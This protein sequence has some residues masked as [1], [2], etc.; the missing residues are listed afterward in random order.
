M[1]SPEC[2]FTWSWTL[3]AVTTLS[4]ICCNDD[5]TR[6]IFKDR[7]SVFSCETI[8][9]TGYELALQADH[10]AACG[11]SSIFPV[12]VVVVVAFSSPTRIW[13]KIF[14]ALI[15]ACALFIYLFIFK[16]RLARAHKFHYL[17]QYIAQ[18]AKKTVAKRNIKSCVFPDSI[19]SPLQLR[20]VKAVWVLRRNL[21]PALSEEWLGSFT[22][23]CGNTGLER[24]PNKSRHR[25][26]TPEK[27]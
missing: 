10:S 8:W 7:H 19:V 27:K 23:H 2:E 26:L 25:K 6:A 16:W 3:C 5:R 13:G 15:P 17:S 4:H 20:L 14:V 9:S 22:C 21:S 18:R 24:T 12:V 1:I 11:F